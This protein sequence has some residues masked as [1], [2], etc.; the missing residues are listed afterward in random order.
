MVAVIQLSSER[1]DLKAVTRHLERDTGLASNHQITVWIAANDQRVSI[2]M[3]VT[4]SYFLSSTVF[5]TSSANASMS[6]LPSCN[7]SKCQQSAHNL[8]WM[9]PRYGRWC[10]CSR[11]CL[12]EGSP[13]RSPSLPSEPRPREPTADHFL[14]VPV[15]RSHWTAAAVLWRRTPLTSLEP[16][17]GWC[18]RGGE[19]RWE[20]VKCEGF[21]GV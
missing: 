14:S 19:V 20:E 12:R 21:R 13:H 15:A 8:S 10:R 6:T 3:R 2:V 7:R 5:D 16:E 9:H 11:A 1:R 18:V 4:G 17:H